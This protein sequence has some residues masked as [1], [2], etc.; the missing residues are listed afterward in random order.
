MGCACSLLH[1][2]FLLGIFFDP[3]DGSYTFLLN[4]SCAEYGILH[5]HRCKN[6]KA[7]RL[8]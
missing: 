4:I 5:N 2:G 1:S 6:L 8:I 3:E 7:Y